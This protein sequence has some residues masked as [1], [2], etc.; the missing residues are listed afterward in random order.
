MLRNVLLAAA[1]VTLGFTAHVVGE[2]ARLMQAEG[3]PGD[4]FL[5]LPEGRILRMASL[6]HRALVADLVWLAAIQYYGEQR[7]TGQRHEQAQR[8]FQVI[9]D[10]DPGF[11]R[12]TRFGALVLAQD[13]RN[14]EG[15][16]A[17]LERA[18]RDDPDAWEYPFDQ[19]F[20]YQTVMKDYEAAGRSY[21]AAAERPG[22][23]D[24]AVRLA[25][26]SFARLGDR[27]T[28]RQVWK[29]LLEEDNEV[30][31][32]IAERSLRNL[33]MEEA[34]D[35]LTDAVTRYR[36]AAGR[37]PSTWAELVS[38]GLIERVPEEPFGGAYAWDAGTGRVWSTTHVDRRMDQECDVFA[39]K[40]KAMREADG[41]WPA[42][43][44]EVVER[45][46]V[47]SEP[48]EPFGLSVE[49]DPA[50]GS[51]S[52]N[53]PWPEVEPGRHGEGRT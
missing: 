14:P 17:L 2:N 12:A 39:G 19:G 13:A 31:V 21:Q 26:V 50:D 16:I 35:L 48:W 37:E 5:Y 47:L 53:P 9:Y 28:A 20:V 11:K 8:L 30:L 46:L 25:G 32:R 51:V 34:Q 44:A 40:L 49:Y 27:E 18:G 3:D 7:I 33:D 29:S 1:A 10:L 43:L 41:R 42:S 52:W 22:A 24:L 38:A 36:A 45:G 15:A 4:D 6:G 23:P